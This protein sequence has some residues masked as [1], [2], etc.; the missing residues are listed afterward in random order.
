M[1]REFTH[2]ELRAMVVKMLREQLESL[3][4]FMERHLGRTDATMSVLQKIIH[5]ETKV[6]KLNEMLYTPHDAFLRFTDEELKV[7][8]LDDMCHTPHDEYLRFKAQ[9]NLDLNVDND[10]IID[11][12]D[13]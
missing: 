7:A 5:V 10:E 3:I 13:D 11:L 6:A 8:A 12:T 4:D 2:A 9:E 1:T